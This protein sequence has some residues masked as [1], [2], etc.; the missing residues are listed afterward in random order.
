MKQTLS[1]INDLKR[2]LAVYDAMDIMDDDGSLY[3][4]IKGGHGSH[5]E[6]V[7][8]TRPNARK[9]VRTASVKQ[10][11]QMVEGKHLA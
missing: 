11:W 9:R 7:R 6:T 4:S 10:I 2:A 5:P 3:I 8:Y 1:T